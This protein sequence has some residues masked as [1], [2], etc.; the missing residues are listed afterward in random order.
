MSDFNHLHNFVADAN[1]TRNNTTTLDNTGFENYELA[2]S[3]RGNASAKNDA[4]GQTGSWYGAIESLDKSD[5]KIFQGVYLANGTYTFATKVQ[6]SGVAARLFVSRSFL[7]DTTTSVA[8]REFSNSNWADQCITF[9]ISTAGV[10]RLGIERGNA[11]S[12]WARIDEARLTSGN[13]CSTS[14]QDLGMRLSTLRSV[15]SSAR[16]FDIRG[17]AISARGHRN[18]G[19]IILTEEKAGVCGVQVLMSEAI[20]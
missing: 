2:W 9:T 13:G 8:S 5:A 7:N 3:L 12:G 6:S 17:R 4:V 10:Y 14:V 1:I 15:N 11:T 18:P 19:G 16:V 20:K